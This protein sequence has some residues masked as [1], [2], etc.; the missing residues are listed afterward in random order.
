MIK[1]NMRLETDNREN[2]AGCRAAANKALGVVSC[3]LKVCAKSE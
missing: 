2:L 1:K 3:T